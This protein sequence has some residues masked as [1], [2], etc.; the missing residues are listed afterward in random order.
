MATINKDNLGENSRL[1]F[2][3]FKTHS[4]LL[5]GVK[6]FIDPSPLG[7]FRIDESSDDWYHE[8][9][10]TD[11]HALDY[12]AYKFYGDE[13]YWWILAIVNDVIDPLTEP[14]IGD[15]IRIPNFSNVLSALR[16]FRQIEP[17]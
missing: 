14:S 12:I 1:R 3:K 17:E 7:N 4:D 15:V 10:L 11:Q 2:L 9:S 8:V 5:G 16:K 13:S 6:E